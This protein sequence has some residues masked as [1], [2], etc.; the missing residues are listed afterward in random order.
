MLIKL[1]LSKSYDR[2]NWD[3][4]REILKYFGFDKEWISWIMALISSSFFVILI[5]GSPSATFKAS[6]GI[7]QGD[8]LSP[9]LFIILGRGTG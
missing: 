3:F 2:I 7:R 1:D 4:L 6:R 9:F 8:P 5:N